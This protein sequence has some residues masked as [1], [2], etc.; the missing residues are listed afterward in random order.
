MPRCCGFSVTCYSL[1]N[2]GHRK[3]K[4]AALVRAVVWAVSA[5]PRCPL[6][7]CSWLGRNGEGLVV[8]RLQSR[9][10]GRITPI[11][12]NTSRDTCS[13]GFPHLLHIKQEV[14]HTFPVLLM[15]LKFLSAHS[16]LSTSGCLGCEFSK[17]SCRA[18]W[19]NFSFRYVNTGIS[20]NKVL[21]TFESI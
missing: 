16:G 6:S 21:V 9:G 4:C 5:V 15:L 13:A 1:S 12:L 20:K 17:V 8:R 18:F 19:P 2:A 7:A 11:I 14:P 3:G 10:R